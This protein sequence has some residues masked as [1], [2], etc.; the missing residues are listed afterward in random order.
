L[1]AAILLKLFIMSRNFSVE[2]FGS[3]R[4]KIMLSSNRDSLTSFFPIWIP[5]YFFFLSYCSG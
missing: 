1:Y 4:Y 5:F 2:F 3:F